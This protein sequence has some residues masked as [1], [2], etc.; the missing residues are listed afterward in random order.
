MIAKAVVNKAPPPIPWMARKAISWV[1]PPPRTGRD[2][3]SPDRPESQEP[4]RKMLIPASRIGLRP[5]RS[6]SLPQIGTM[7][8]EDSR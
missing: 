1:M 3:N 8:V 7:T 5:N 4:A 2:P 6:P